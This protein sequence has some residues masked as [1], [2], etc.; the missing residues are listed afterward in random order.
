MATFADIKAIRLILCDP[1]GVVNIDQVADESSLPANPTKQTA[2]QSL[3]SDRYYVTD[4][5]APLPTDWEQPKLYLSDATIGDLFDAYGQDDAVIKCA[6]RIL[7]KLFA[8]LKIVRINSGTEST[9]YVTLKEA[10]DYMKGLI[11]DYKDERAENSNTQ[12][13]Q[14]GHIRRPHIAG[15]NL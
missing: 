7:P 10:Y 11:S 9:D 8:E 3:T 1:S 13:G 14:Y 4:K 15:G 12:A 6:R 5:D 2:Y